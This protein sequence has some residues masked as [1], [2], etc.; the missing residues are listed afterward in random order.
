[1]RGINSIINRA[2][3]PKVNTIKERTDLTKNKDVNLVHN[4]YKD[5]HLLSNLNN[6]EDFFLFLRNMYKIDDKYL[7]PNV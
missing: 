3:L 4:K 7:T 5:T 2:K 6:N 1:M